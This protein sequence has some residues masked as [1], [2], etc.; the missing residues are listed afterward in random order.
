MR[1]IWALSR[2]NCYPP[3]R[4]PSPFVV[5][6][7]TTRWSRSSGR[8][9]PGWPRSVHAWIS[10]VS[11]STFDGASSRCAV[12]ADGLFCCP[13][14]GARFPEPAWRR[15]GWYSPAPAASISETRSAALSQVE[16]AAHH[17]QRLRN[18]ETAHRAF[19]GRRASRPQYPLR[20][21]TRCSSKRIRHLGN[22]YGYK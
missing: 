11:L 17:Q 22:T 12:H 13:V 8:L 18:T 6:P 4:S 19:G 2:W 9:R 5:G 20:I 14:P 21:S 7:I 3:R 16:D 10:W 15:R 1:Q